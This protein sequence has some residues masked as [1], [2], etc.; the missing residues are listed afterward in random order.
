MRMEDLKVEKLLRSSYSG[1]DEKTYLQTYFES[2]C[3]AN[4]MCGLLVCFCR[5]YGDRSGEG[6]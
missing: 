6:Y 5:I 1:G 2:I 3:I 4:F